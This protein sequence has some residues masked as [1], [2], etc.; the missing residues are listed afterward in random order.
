MSNVWGDPATPKKRIVLIIDKRLLGIPVEED[1]KYECRV[2]LKFYPMAAPE[3]TITLERF[4][5]RL[6]REG[7]RLAEKIEQILNSAGAGAASA[8]N[9]KTPSLITERK[10]K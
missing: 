9:K 7:Y 3:D 4:N 2:Q 5:M 10:G 6:E 1:G 8:H